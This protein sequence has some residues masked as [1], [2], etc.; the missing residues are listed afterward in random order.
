MRVLF[1]TLGS[2]G[3]LNPY[4]A[5]GRELRARGH[6][7]KVAT[8]EYYRAKVEAN[9]FEFAPLRPFFTPDDKEM[10]SRA[11]DARNGSE[12]ILRELVF[13]YLRQTFDDLLEA[14]RDRD[15]LVTQMLVFV[16]PLVAEKT[17]IRWASSV[18]APLSFL[19]AYDPLVVGL[20]PWLESVS[21][22]GPVVNGLLCRGAKAST[23]GWTQPVAALRSELGL[24]QAQANPIFEGQHSPELVLAM[25]SP[26]FAEPRA[27]WP[28]RT[29][30][31]GFVHDDGSGKSLDEG[32]ES[33]LAQG[34]APLV[35]TLGTAAI[36]VAGNFF[37]QSAEAARLLRRRA[38]LLIGDDAGN[39]EVGA[40]VASREIY[41]AKY[42][43]YSKL[44]PKAAAIVHQGGIGT[45][46]EALRA[47]RPMLVVPFSNDQPDNASRVKRLGVARSLER[48]EYRA[49]RVAAELSELL[50][51][52]AHEEAAAR[53]SVLLK[54][55]NGV[56]AA[57]AELERLVSRPKL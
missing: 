16:G 18:L 38:V 22:L 4:L 33:F 46:A 44:F 43:P 56:T 25:F 49:A 45:T 35:F 36:H 29:V 32:L 37:E 53:L 30:V 2:H 3:D 39:D 1:A 31:T 57:C 55:E 34:P 28:A 50:S 51:N 42:A 15:L 11:M 52:P 5:L 19:S 23:A 20:A 12:Y 47:G 27:D 10:V 26:H 54:S 24:P 41:V 40:K 14:A 13:P 8:T 17:G 21:A 6:S 7:V 9:G 48:S